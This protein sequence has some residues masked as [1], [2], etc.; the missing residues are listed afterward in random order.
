MKKSFVEI[1]SDNNGEYLKLLSAISK[2]SGLF[3]DST[4]P[5][6]N[7]RVAENVFCR[8]FSAGNISRSDTA[9]DANYSSMGV[10]LKTFVATGNDKLEKVAE[11]NQLSEELKT[12]SGKNLAIRLGE[13]RNSRIEL[14]DNLYGISESCYHIVA[15]KPS[16][17]FIFETDY[18]KVDVSNINSVRNKQGKTLTFEDG[19]HF[20]SYTFSKSTLYRRFVIPRN[21]FRLPVEILQDPYTLL[22]RLFA[23]KQA[24]IKPPKKLIK[25]V[26]FVILPLYGIKEGKKFVFEKSGLNQWNSGGR[27]RNLGEV[28]IPVPIEI[29]KKYAGFFPKKDIS[30]NLKIPTGEIFSAKLCQQD[31]KALMTNP[32]KALSDWLL[33]KLL[34]L[35]EGEFATI[36]KLE[37]LGFDSVVVYKDD[38]ENFRIDKAKSDS[39]ENFIL[40]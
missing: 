40:D 16:E 22:L 38:Q 9:Y 19:R 4:T 26:E 21:A 13:Y 18:S 1:D 8:S 7:Y 3:S 6:I 27:T 37:K 14:A 36:E 29:H 31:S 15:R 11:F 12:L 20:Y 34:Q 25:G 35:K 23:E 28:Y 39:Y 10:G 30:F 17:L 33:R 24:V 5:F 32:N 2:L